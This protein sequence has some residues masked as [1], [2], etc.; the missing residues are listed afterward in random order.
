MSLDGRIAIPSPRGKGML[1]PKNTSNELDW[2]LYQELAAQADLILSTGR[3][4]RDWADGKAQEI[5]QTDNPKFKDLREWRVARGLKPHPDIAIISGS[6][7]F[8]IPKVLTAEGRKAIF[9][10]T[11]NPDKT[12]VKEIE[13]KAGP[14]YVAGRKRVTGKLLQRR[15]REL[16]YR[17]V[18]SSAGPQVLHLLLEGKVL[19]R[20]YLTSANRI[21]GGE[22]FDTIL[23]G[24]LLKPTADFRLNSLYYDAAA[25][26]GLG[27]LFACYENARRT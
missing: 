2:R 13:E 23:T 11:A 24:P 14:V 18:Y 26:D 7:E 19:D 5:L 4:L 20:L 8:P 10:T 21:L 17:T 1:V 12:R 16:G 9:F 3:Y 27:Q 22:E 15:I 6:L 25:L